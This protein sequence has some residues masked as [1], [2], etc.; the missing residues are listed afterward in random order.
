MARLLNRQEDMQRSLELVPESHGDET[1][2]S[3]PW[4]EIGD[5]AANA[6]V[7]LYS[8]AYINFLCSTC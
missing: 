1:G 4:T 7:G 3:V 2:D 8:Y 6:R 5:A